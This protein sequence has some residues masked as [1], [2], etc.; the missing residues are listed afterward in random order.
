MQHAIGILCVPGT[1]VIYIYRD[2]DPHH[3]RNLVYFL[4]HGVEGDEGNVDHVIVVQLVRSCQSVLDRMYGPESG[5]EL[6]HLLKQI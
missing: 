2:S 4:K 6:L 1:L 5:D 3:K